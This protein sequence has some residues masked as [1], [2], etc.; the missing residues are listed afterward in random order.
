[1]STVPRIYRR[2]RIYIVQCTAK[3]DL[4]KHQLGG[5]KLAQR[6]KANVLWFMKMVQP[7]EHGV[8]NAS[9]VRTLYLYDSLI[10]LMLI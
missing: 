8:D 2:T 5:S 4:S 3:V 7:T 6:D 10:H 9:Q 1:M